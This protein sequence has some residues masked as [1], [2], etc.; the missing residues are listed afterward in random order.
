MTHRSIWNLDLGLWNHQNHVLAERGIKAWKIRYDN[1][2]H[3]WFYFHHQNL[4]SS[5]KINFPRFF[6]TST[7]LFCCANDEKQSVHLPSLI[8]RCLNVLANC[9][10]SSRSVVSSGSNSRAG[11]CLIWWA[12]TRILLLG[13]VVLPDCWDCGESFWWWWWDCFWSCCNCWAAWATACW[14]WGQRGDRV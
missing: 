4:F 12:G 14:T 8:R 3:K 9:S 6:P 7:P 10:N 13:G 5:S 1:H 2:N 11:V